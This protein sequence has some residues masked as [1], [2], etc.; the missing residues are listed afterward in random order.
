MGQARIVLFALLLV[1]ACDGNPFVESTDNGGGSGGGTGGG[2]GGGDDTGGGIDSDRVLP[3]GTASPSPA[4]NIF[5]REARN[6]DNGNGFAEGIRYNAADDTFFVDGLAFDGAN[7]YQR[8]TPVGQLG[9]FA[10]YEADAIYNDDRT[11]A[12]INQF[13]HRAV[14]GVSTSGNTEFA[15]VRTGAYTGYGFGGFVYQRTGS[16]TLPTSGQ[17]TFSGDY[18]GLRD[19]SNAGGLEYTRGAMTV[20]IDFN[21]FND[22][23]AV[24][25]R[26]ENRSIFDLNGN[27]ITATV[28][29]ALSDKTDRQQTQLP[30]LLF[31]VGPGVLDLNGE[32]LGTLD[33]T[34][35]DGSGRATR[36]EDGNYYAVISG[37]QA[38]EMVGV[39]VVTSADPRIDGVTARET[40]GFI[41]YRP[42][43]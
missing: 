31:R 32:I 21:D 1:A 7:T 25:G 37:D 15:L 28:L 42:G 17:A 10:V 40:G 27:D 8:G 29:A 30:T 23:Y 6:T 16:V 11:G 12:P 41:L 33:S 34:V 43:P 26:V 14:Y 19:F 18:A 38:N 24:K 4:T 20:D 39:I 2:T 35:V 13:G 9:P 22:G 3:P 36:F 5:R